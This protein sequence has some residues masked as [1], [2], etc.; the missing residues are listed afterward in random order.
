M[1]DWFNAKKLKENILSLSSS[2]DWDIAKWERLLDHIYFLD[3]KIWET[4]WSCLCWHYPI[5][6]VC[7]IKNTINW[8]STEVGNQCIKKFMPSLDQTNIFDSLSRIKKNKTTSP[9][10]ELINYS[11]IKA[12]INDWEKKFCLSTHGKKTLSAKQKDIRIK[13]NNK[14]INHLVKT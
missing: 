2:N 12:F 6:E 3:P 5:Q 14:I 4:L 13:I 7:V 10:I 1:P 9:S 8:E 11:Y